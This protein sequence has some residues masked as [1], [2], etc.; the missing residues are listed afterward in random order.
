MSSSKGTPKHRIRTHDDE[1]IQRRVL[2]KSDR[3]RVRRDRHEQL[4]RQLLREIDEL[5]ERPL[6]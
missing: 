3:S 4:R 1:R 2:A 6:S 5:L